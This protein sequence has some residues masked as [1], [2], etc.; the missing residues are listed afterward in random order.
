MLS[1]SSDDEDDDGRLA[2]APRNFR[3]RQFF[4]L[5][6]FYERFRLT[7]VQAEELLGEIGPQIDR[8]TNQSHALC[9][10]QK[11]LCALRFYACGSFYYSVGDSHGIS[12]SSSCRAVHLVTSILIS[13]LFESMVKWPDNPA[14]GLAQWFYNVPRLMGMPTVCG[15]IKDTLIPILAPSENEEQ[16]VDD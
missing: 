12:K 5:E 9:A 2:P 10:R 16:F 13:K 1:S 7:R 15:C 11:L 6:N 4:E 8:D 14:A 3:K